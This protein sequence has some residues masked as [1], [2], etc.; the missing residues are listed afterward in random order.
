MRIIGCRKEFFVELAELLK[1][2]E[3]W[4]HEAGGHLG[5]L[6]KIPVDHP[7]KDNLLLFVPE[8]AKEKV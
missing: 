7:D 3:R 4:T 6:L 5:L 1:P 2:E 8:L